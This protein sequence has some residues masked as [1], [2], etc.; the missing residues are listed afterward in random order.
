MPSRVLI[1]TQVASPVP[2]R[3]NLP[4]HGPGRLVSYPAGL[5]YIAGLCYTAGLSYV[6]AVYP[7]G[8][9]YTAGLS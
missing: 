4:F 8:L 9:S 3:W 7:A 2:V 5:C 6:A 1:I